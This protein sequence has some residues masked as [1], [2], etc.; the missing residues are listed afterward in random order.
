MRMLGMRV[1]MLVTMLLLVMVIW[2][3]MLTILR[4]LMTSSLFLLT[5]SKIYEAFT[6]H[7]A[8]ILGVM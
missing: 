7:S 3:M 1:M 5:C 4:V 6:W 8:V 2:E